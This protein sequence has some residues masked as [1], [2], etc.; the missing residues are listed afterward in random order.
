MGGRRWR[1]RGR[2][3]QEVQ[4]GDLV[5]VQSDLVEQWAREVAPGVT[6]R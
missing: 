3:S 1:V 4:E 5:F 6:N 2:S